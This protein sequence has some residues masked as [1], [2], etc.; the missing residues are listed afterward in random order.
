M[1]NIKQESTLV[2]SILIAI[3]GS[4]ENAVSYDRNIV[5]SIVDSPEIMVRMKA[6]EEAPLAKVDL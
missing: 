4:L 3:C 5:E 2:D 1:S 6:E